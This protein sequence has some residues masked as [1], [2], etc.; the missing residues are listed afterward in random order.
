V[1][2]HKYIVHIYRQELFHESLVNAKWYY[3]LFLKKPFYNHPSFLAVILAPSIPMC[4]NLAAK[5]T[6]NWQQWLWLMFIPVLV[7]IVFAIGSRIGLFIY[8]MLIVLCCVYFFKKLNL[9]SICVIGAMLG[10]A[11]VVSKFSTIDYTE[12][13]IRKEMNRFAIEK[14]KER[15]LLGYGYNTQLEQIWQLN[16]SSGYPILLELD[17]NTR[18]HLHNQYLEEIFQ[19]GLIG[20]L[21]FFFLLLY[22]IYLGVKKRDVYLLS[23]LLIYLLFFCVDTADTRVKGIMP[24]MLLTTLIMNVLIGQPNRIASQNESTPKI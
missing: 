4:F 21:P 6:K 8:G 5:A 23:F 17:D 16:E 7:F 15:P 1:I 14:I 12:D 22:L 11:L 10:V 20:A 2:L 9:V 3:W 18:A 24:M 13:P 19:F